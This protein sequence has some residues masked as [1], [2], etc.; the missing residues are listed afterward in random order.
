MDYEIYLLNV[1]KIHRRI[2]EGTKTL[3]TLRCGWN[4][5]HSG[6]LSIRIIQFEGSLKGVSFRVWSL[7]YL[8]R[9][10]STSRYRMHADLRYFKIRPK[11]RLIGAQSQFN[12]WLEYFLQ[13]IRMCYFSNKKYTTT[14]NDISKAAMLYYYELGPNHESDGSNHTE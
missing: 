14:A 11:R 1:R 13:S 12:I 8:V 3:G 9:E 7:F 10:N 2:I 6:L 5:S 4:T